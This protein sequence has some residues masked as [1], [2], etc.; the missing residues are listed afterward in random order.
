MTIKKRSEI[1]K[2]IIEL[3]LIT[4]PTQ[5]HKKLIQK[6]QQELDNSNY[7]KDV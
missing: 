4:S 2:Q 5:G 6:L 7:G 1:T 3:K